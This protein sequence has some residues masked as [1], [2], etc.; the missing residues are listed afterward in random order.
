MHRWLRRARV[1]WRGRVDERGPR[2]RRS[3]RA[4]Q[5]PG[6]AP[7]W[8]PRR[9]ARARGSRLRRCRAR[10]RA[11]RRGAMPSALNF[12]PISPA[13]SSCSPYSDCVHDLPVAH[14]ARVVGGEVLQEM[15][16]A[17]GLVVRA[18]RG[19]GAGGNSGEQGEAA[20]R[21]KPDNERFPRRPRGA[22]ARAELKIVFN[23]A[24]APPPV[25]FHAFS[26]P[27]SAAR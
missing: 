10:R 21:R 18:R 5:R 1:P 19:G 12:A 26:V 2:A 6:R 7:A 23:L 27:S 17:P 14:R 11:D 25:R 24:S 13:N 9:R 3:V 22:A 8:P 15:G 4:R 16:G 20:G